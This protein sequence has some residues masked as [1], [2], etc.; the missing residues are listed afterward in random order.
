[1]ATIEERV[2]A[3]KF[4]GE[5][6]LAGVDKSLSKLDQLNN[7]LKMQEGTKGLS[8]LGAAAQKQNGALNTVAE[9]VSHISDRFKALSVVG[10][11]ALNNITNQAI[12]AGQNM[13]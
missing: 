12:F 13:L 8:N 10:I 9:S 4:Q 5:Q 3:M 6:F 11:S 2:V 1:M 7:K